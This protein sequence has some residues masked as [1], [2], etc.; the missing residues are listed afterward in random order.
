[1]ALYSLI[2][3]RHDT[4][5]A[6]RRDH[7]WLDVP[8][9]IA[10]ISVFFDE[11]GLAMRM[12]AD[13]Q[14]GGGVLGAD[15]AMLGSEVLFA[16]AKFAAKV[17]EPHILHDSEE[18]DVWRI[19]DS[20]A[21]SHRD[22]SLT[23]FASGRREQMLEDAYQIVRRISIER[24]GAKMAGPVGR[25]SRCRLEEACAA[26]PERLCDVDDQHRAFF[27]EAR[28]WRLVAIL[29]D[30][31]KQLLGRMSYDRVATPPLVP[32]EDAIADPFSSALV[33]VLFDISPVAFSITTTGIECSRYV[34]V[35]QAYLDLVGTN[36]AEIRGMEMVG[37]G[38]VVADGARLRR[39]E[40][41]NEIGSYQGEI[42]TIR[43]ASGEVTKVVISAKRLCIGGQMYD[44]EAMAP[45][46]DP[47]GER[48]Q[49]ARLPDGMEVAS[50]R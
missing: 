40:R 5:Q 3:L 39:L 46:P 13:W 43:K 11:D 38:L 27:A 9:D 22:G 36:W 30:E 45:L 16:L 19:L 26:L 42:A 18:E 12:T 48:P 15:P 29:V 4:L 1:V 33:E 21:S 35:N 14:T 47:L 50:D 37:S 7:P 8:A 23:E 25:Q 24:L 34:R 41:L 28:T 49:D 20:L 10:E 32:G 2:V 44:F 17:G 6:F 31:R